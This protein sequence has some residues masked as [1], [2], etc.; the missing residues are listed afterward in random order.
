MLNNY[1]LLFEGVESGSVL[2]KIY[3]YAIREP[4]IATE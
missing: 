4:V 2:K 3:I 1:P